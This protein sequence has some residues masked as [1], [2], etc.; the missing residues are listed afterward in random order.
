MITLTSNYQGHGILNVEYSYY[1][2]YSYFAHVKIVSRRH[3]L[4]ILRYIGIVVSEI[5]Y[6]DAWH[7]NSCMNAFLGLHKHTYTSI[8]IT[9]QFNNYHFF[10]LDYCIVWLANSIIS[11]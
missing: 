9:S 11:N 10:F 5:A 2:S 7:V 1:S 3:L 8:Y 6:I 4:Y